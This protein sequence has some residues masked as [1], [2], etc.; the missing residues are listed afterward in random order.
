MVLC[1]YGVCVLEVSGGRDI[2]LSSGGCQIRCDGSLSELVV[3]LLVSF[4]V[5]LAEGKRGF[6]EC[7]EVIYVYKS[8]VHIHLKRACKRH[9]K[10]A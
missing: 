8:P 10:A 2:F 5:A 6:W 1:L 4:C 9:D 7:Q 3:F